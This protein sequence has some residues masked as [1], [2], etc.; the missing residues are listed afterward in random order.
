MFQCSSRTSTSTS[1]TYAVGAWPYHRHAC[2][3][4]PSLRPRSRTLSIRC[5]GQE[6]KYCCHFATDLHTTSK[7]LGVAIPE[8]VERKAPLI[9]S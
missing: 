6:M 7:V 4:F 2:I 1:T 8:D 9:E 3:P 5:Q